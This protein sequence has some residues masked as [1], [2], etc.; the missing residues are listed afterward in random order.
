MPSAVDQEWVK[1]TDPRTGRVFYANRRTRETQWEPPFGWIDEDDQ[2][3][4]RNTSTNSLPIQTQNTSKDSSSDLPSNWEEMHDHKTGRPFYVDHVNKVTS[5]ERPKPVNES[6]NPYPNH[7]LPERSPAANSNYYDSGAGKTVD[8]RNLYS[9]NEHSAWS[10]KPSQSPQNHSS[11]PNNVA[12]NCS[13]Y[14]NNSGYNA[15]QLEFSFVSVKDEARTNCPGCGVLFSKPLKRK[16]HCRLCGDVFCDACTTKR[17]LLPLDGPEYEKPVRVCDWCETDIQS[18]NYFTMRRYLPS[19][20]LFDP[21]ESL[22]AF[23]TN[24]DGNYEEG[25]GI[26]ETQVNAALASLTSDLNSVLMDAT[27][28]HE[29]ITASAETLV[30]AITRHLEYSGTSDRAICALSTLLALGKIVG[31]NSFANAVYM[32]ARGTV[33]MESVLKL[34]EQSGSSKHTLFYQEQAA[35]AIFYLSDEDL[36]S[37]ITPEDQTLD[38]HRSLRNMLDHATCSA[39]PSLQRWAAACIR[40]LI[41][42]DMHRTTLYANTDTSYDSFTTQLVNTGGVMILCSLIAGEDADTRAHAISALSAVIRAARNLNQTKVDSD[43]ITA[44]ANSGGCGEAISHLLLSADTNVA[45]MSV[46]F[47]SH[48]V[49][50][51]LGY[52]VVPNYLDSGMS[53]ADFLRPYCDAAIALVLE[54]N[55]LQALVQLVSPSSMYQQK[56]TLIELK[57]RAMETLSAIA[58]ACNTHHESSSAKVRDVKAKIL[59]LQILQTAFDILRSNS[60]QSL[61]SARDSPETQLRE[62]AGLFIGQVLQLDESSETLDYL[63]ANKG[64]IVFLTLA[65]DDGMFQPSGLVGEW[66]PRCLSWVEAASMLLTKVWYKGQSLLCKS[67]TVQRGGSVASTTSNTG[68]SS[69][70]L[71]CLLEVI[72]AGAVQL[73]TQ[74]LARRP[75][76]NTM[77]EEHLKISACHVIA[78]MFGIAHG[79]T[80]NIGTLRLYDAVQASASVFT[81]VGQRRSG[82]DLIMLTLSFLQS[83]CRRAHNGESSLN[84]LVEAALMAAGSVCGTYIG[85]NTKNNKFLESDKAPVSRY[86]QKMDRKQFSNHLN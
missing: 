66:A 24:D 42:Q 1:S 9:Q 73:L 10:S 36:L 62:A 61:N 3:P 64:A 84:E 43:L 26:T 13:D 80:T 5:W 38:L 12:F 59:S 7:F 25:S 74:I 70:I 8:V 68:F 39:S 22:N 30:P 23:S 77:G 27:S 79:D 82:N 67:P 72:D 51:L 69:E 29:K 37:S 15:P 81:A 33:I 20:E 6:P 34:L 49:A 28:F 83:V 31:D 65:G 71:D 21:K 54:G 11:K 32:Q 76:K 85:C 55:C 78:A 40:N 2:I 19:L 47:A 46:T 75:N 52:K 4:P 86:F 45:Q 63:S 16:H 35:R 41:I 18:G 57:V 48:L 58:I 56:S 14:L 53:R 50:P 60:T 17:A 44:I